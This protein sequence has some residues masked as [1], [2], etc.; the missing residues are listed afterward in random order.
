MDWTSLII[1][2]FTSV[3]TIVKSV[4]DLM[5]AGNGEDKKQAAVGNIVSMAKEAGVDDAHIEAL[6]RKAGSVVD[7]VVAA[8]NA[9][10]T[11]KKS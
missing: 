2:I 11:F 4:E 9:S 3:P 7:T 6:S 10:G 5:G 1:A 8:Y